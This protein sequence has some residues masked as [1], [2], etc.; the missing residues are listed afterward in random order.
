ML[1]VLRFE[2][3]KAAG[4]L[5]TAVGLES[6]IHLPLLVQQNPNLVNLRHGAQ[7]IHILKLQPEGGFGMFI[8]RLF[9]FIYMP[10]DI[11]DL[12]RSPT[13]RS[14]FME[15]SRIKLLSNQCK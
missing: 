14:Y 13:G 3:L 11:M 9:E 7:L 1:D 8:L 2:H 6:G 10:I 15:V 12:F 4:R 5:F